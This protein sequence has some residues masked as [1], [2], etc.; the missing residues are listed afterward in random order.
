MMALK[1]QRR[2]VQR[3][4]SIVTVPLLDYE[5]VLNVG[6]SIHDL[7][8]FESMTNGRHYEHETT[9]LLM[10]N[11]QGGNFFVDVGANNGYYSL[12][13]SSLVGR[14]GR[15]FS[16][17]P[18]PSSFRRLLNNLSYNKV[19]NVTPFNLALSD[20]QEV[21][22]LYLN[23]FED[24]QSSMVRSAKT[25]VPV[26]TIRLDDVVSGRLPDLVKID[27]EGAELKVLAGM[28]NTLSSQ[29]SLRC[30]VE[31]GRDNPMSQALWKMLTQHFE[32]YLID[33]AESGQKVRLSP[34]LSIDELPGLCNL[35]CVGYK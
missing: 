16:F 7:M 20:A 6:D 23:R 13:A 2:L 24:G 15:V 19:T 9:L 33:E 32:V 28:A 1:R 17:E 10:E 3:L 34:V 27:V 30:I 22:P 26:P 4:G 12:L 29:K 18:N 14:E 25:S 8:M 21:V 31:W 35:W 11:L 5:L